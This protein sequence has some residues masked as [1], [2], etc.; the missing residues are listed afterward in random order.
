VRIYPDVVAV[1]AART[2]LCQ[3]V[4]LRGGEGAS[5]PF[6][7]L[8]EDLRV[9]RVGRMQSSGYALPKISCRTGGTGMFSYN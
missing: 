2:L 8:L 5:L 9:G 6:L 1:W 7:P 4:K 3:D